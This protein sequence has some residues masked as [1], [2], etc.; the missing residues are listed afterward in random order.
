MGEESAERNTVV[1]CKSEE[2]AG[3]SCDVVDASKYGHG[4]SDRGKS[5]G[6][7]FRLR[8]IVDDLDE[9]LLR[10]GAENAIDVRSETETN[11]DQ[12]EEAKGAVHDSSP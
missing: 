6:T 7:G 10:V 5:C 11:G 2:L 12:H 9:R 4:D 3:A 1:S 8:C